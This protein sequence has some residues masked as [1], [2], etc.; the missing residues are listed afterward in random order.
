MKWA[1]ITR[2]RARAH[3]RSHRHT[4]KRTAILLDGPIGSENL[5]VEH[6]LEVLDGEVDGR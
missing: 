4:L 6:V 5:G 3:V 2:A 1:S